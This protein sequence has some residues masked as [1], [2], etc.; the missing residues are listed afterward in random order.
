M[1]HSPAFEP[2]SSASGQP[3]QAQGRGD[4]PKGTLFVVSAPSGAGKT[5]LVRALLDGHPNLRLSVS[6]TTRTPRAGEVDGVHYH[7]VSRETF[8]HMVRQNAFVEYAQ[9]FD[10]AYGTAR[11]TL[12]QALDD[13]QDLLLEI[14][15][16]GARQVRQHFPEAVS[17]FI[18]PPSL[19]ELERRL[20]ER[21]QDSDETIA[22]RMAEAR[23]ELSHYGEYDYLIVN[24]RFEAAL[25][26]LRALVCAFGLRRARQQRKLGGALHAMLESDAEAAPG[27]C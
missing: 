7:F 23:G 19:R 1:S 18:L 27:G 12:R 6:Y 5:S 21:A 16:Q 11:E 9:V 17:I 4:D 3:E 15:W 2:P 22:R 20:R 26:E 14:D 25:T 10:N 13:G 8:E 24:D